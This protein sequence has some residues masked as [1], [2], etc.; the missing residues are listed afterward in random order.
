MDDILKQILNELRELRQGQEAQGKELKELRLGQEAQGKEL[1]ELR[2]GQEAQGK[3]LREL[4]RGQEAQGEELRELRQGQE[5]QGKRLERLEEGQGKLHSD[6][7][8]LAVH[9]EGEITEKIRGLYDARGQILDS[10]KRIEER[11]D[12]QDERLNLHWQEIQV[13]RTKRR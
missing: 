3:E 1:K 6:L 10:L 7:T 13:L 9:V 12:R 8:K 2:L 5:A 11:Q 4:R